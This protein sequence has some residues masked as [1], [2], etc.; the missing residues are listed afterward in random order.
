MDKIKNFLKIN[1]EKIKTVFLVVS[2][3]VIIY[4]L[5]KKT[6]ITFSKNDAKYLIDFVSNDLITTILGTLLG[7]YIAFKTAKYTLDE[8]LKKQ[9]QIEY[10]K[11]KLEND[12]KNV[13]NLINNLKTI[14][15]FLDS[16][17]RRNIEEIIV[18]K[19]KYLEILKTNEGSIILLPN[20]KKEFIDLS[21]E[22]IQ[23][24]EKIDKY[25]SKIQGLTE[26]VPANTSESINTFI[27]LIYGQVGVKH[28]ITQIYNAIS[29]FL[30][31]KLPKNLNGIASHELFTDDLDVSIAIISDIIE[32]DLPKEI[33]NL[34]NNLGEKI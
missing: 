27:N 23:N 16:D 28:T 7:G 9:S 19:N 30:Y 5:T 34:V 4:L 15:Q 22:L 13:H 6:L 20:I 24:Y 31:D 33:N 14:Q 10:E 29:P 26:I 17:Y 21:H 18:E 25:K 2:V 3:F 11:I 32:I 1:E 8:Q 12:I